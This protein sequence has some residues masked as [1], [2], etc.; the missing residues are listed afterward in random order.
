MICYSYLIVNCLSILF[1][2]LLSFDKKVAF[3]KNW[4]YLLIAN[5]F[6]ATV[7]VIWDILFTHLGVWGF[8]DKYLMGF[9]FFN[10]PVEELMFFFCI[11][12]C[13]IFLFEVVKSYFSC[14]FNYKLVHNFL[15]ILLMCSIFF[16]NGLYTFATSQV[17]M[18]LL[19][20][21]Y[22]KSYMANFYISFLISLLPFLLVN[23]VLTGMF[24]EPPIVWYNNH[25]NIGL[26][27]ISIPVEDVF[28]GMSLILL[29]IMFY[30]KLKSR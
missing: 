23:G 12:Y 20:L 15:L 8:T 6:S 26:R 18:I 21:N 27:I 7:F 30:E 3:Y 17:L 28:Y 16:F 29:T 13:C 2:F 11:P 22:H 4:K 10:L 14:R 19:L 5:I 25:E 9:K 24:F 1:P